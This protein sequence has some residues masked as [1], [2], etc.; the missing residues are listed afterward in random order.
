MNWLQ[1]AWIVVGVI[2]WWLTWEYLVKALMFIATIPYIIL[3]FV[4]RFFMGIN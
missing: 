1:W 4:F 2:V 3:G